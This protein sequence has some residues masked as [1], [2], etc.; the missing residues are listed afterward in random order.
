MG[1]F[2]RGFVGLLGKDFA[3]LDRAGRCGQ[4]REGVVYDGTLTPV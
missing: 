1:A 4:L 3:G 2:G